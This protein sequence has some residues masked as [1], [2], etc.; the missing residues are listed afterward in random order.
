MIIGLNKQLRFFCKC[1]NNAVIASQSADWRGNPFPFMQSIFSEILGK[2][3]RFG[4]GLPRR[5]APR[6]D[7]AGRNPVIKTRMLTK[8]D[9]HNS[10]FKMGPTRKLEVQHSLRRVS[11]ALWVVLGLFFS[12][13]GKNTPRQAVDIEKI[14][15]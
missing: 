6:N 14:M 13:S 1:Q 2:L 7:S 12:V 15:F 8:T 5:F 11:A 3:R 4:N 10:N 9:S